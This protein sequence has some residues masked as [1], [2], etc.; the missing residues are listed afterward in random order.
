M[1]GEISSTQACTMVVMD[2]TLA[3]IGTGTATAEGHTLALLQVAS[4]TE[5]RL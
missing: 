4:S 3:A 2:S 5:D 1:L